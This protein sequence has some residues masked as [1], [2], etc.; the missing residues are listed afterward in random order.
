MHG[1]HEGQEKLRDARG[2]DETSCSPLLALH[3]HRGEVTVATGAACWCLQAASR[4]GTCW[5]QEH[6][7]GCCL[8]LPLSF[9]QFICLLH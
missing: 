6:R 1:P 5:G 2:C 8:R 9:H 7:A 4:A 3:G